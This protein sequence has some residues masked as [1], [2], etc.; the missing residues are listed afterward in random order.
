MRKES[1]R[2]RAA[3]HRTAVR[4]IQQEIES[5]LPKLLQNDWSTEDLQRLRGMFDKRSDDLIKLA[6][7]QYD[8]WFGKKGTSNP[9]SEYDLLE[10]SERHE[11]VH[12]ALERIR[13][14]LRSA[15]EDGVTD[16][17]VE[18]IRAIAL[19]IERR[20]EAQKKSPEEAARHRQTVL[21]QIVAKR[22]GKREAVAS[23][24]SAAC[25]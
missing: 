13:D 22:R 6:R 20:R 16:G 17:A 25:G 5:E 24:V 12:E 2:E 8:Q 15:S 23:L 21:A 18:C 19:R 3:D 10:K 14:I 11:A 4:C 1:L 9:L 7:G